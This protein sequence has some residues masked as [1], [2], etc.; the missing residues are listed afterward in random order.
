MN[1]GSQIYVG[2]DSLIRPNILASC[3]LA[4]V[5]VFGR[6]TVTG[7]DYARLL[8][9]LAGVADDDQSTTERDPW[10]WIEK[11]A[12]SLEGPI[13]GAKNLTNPFSSAYLLQRAKD[14]GYVEFIPFDIWSEGYFS[15]LFSPETARLLQTGEV[16][17]GTVDFKKWDR[18]VKPL[19]RAATEHRKWFEIAQSPTVTLE[20]DI[21]W[22]YIAGV[23]FAAHK[24]AVVSTCS[25]NYWTWL[26]RESHVL[27]C[28]SIKTTEI[29]RLIEVFH[30]RFTVDDV[31]HFIE[32]RPVLEDLLA[33]KAEY[34]QKIK[35][36][37][38][39]GKESFFLLLQEVVG[40]IASPVV[41]SFE[42]LKMI[43]R[44]D[45]KRWKRNP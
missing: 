29:A 10:P 26:Q 8:F 38:E 34:D 15:L 21:L 28:S 2:L 33:V 36:S 4:Y 42:I 5:P 24:N 14:L 22:S 30:N 41:T 25:K 35:T 40:A 13:Q 43:C 1:A 31:F 11:Y 3:L 9:A 6:I 19:V 23:G 18:F 45:F 32:E 44:L 17:K 27:S 39:M 37:A 16:A 20:T 7:V 12:D